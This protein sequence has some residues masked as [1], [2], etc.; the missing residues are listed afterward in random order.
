MQLNPENIANW[1]FRLNG[2]TTIP[3]LV[4]HPDRPGE[5]QRTDVDVL[6]VR[7]PHR[8]EL[9]TS[10]NPMKDH[11][12]FNESPQIDIILA[13]VKHSMCSLNGP[14]TNPN[15]QNLYRVLYAIGAFPEENVPT[16]A[17]D[18]YSYG[19]YSDSQFQVRLLT[20]GNMRNVEILPGATQLLWDDL[21]EFIFGRF[22]VFAREKAHHNQWDS[23]GQTLYRLATKRNKTK[24][25]FV[26]EVKKQMQA[27]IDNWVTRR[28]EKVET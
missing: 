16:V 26:S 8:K 10:G 28:S 2:C 14:W 11:E 22:Q 23:T 4:V 15:D 20:I 13:E 21:I 9:L 17:G 24:D 3:N 12:I 7:F 18:L 6:A 5:S 27:Y 1:F 25:V 19:Q